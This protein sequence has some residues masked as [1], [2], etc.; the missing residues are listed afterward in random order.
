[1]TYGIIFVYV[2]VILTIYNQQITNINAVLDEFN[3]IRQP[4]QFTT[5]MECDIT[6]N[7]LDTST[8]RHDH[9]LSVQYTS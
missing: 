1:M 2:D 4:L 6:L 5:D 3:Q 7:L 9:E 8:T